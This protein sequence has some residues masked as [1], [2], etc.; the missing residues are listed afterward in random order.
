MSNHPE[1]GTVEVPTLISTLGAYAWRFVAFALALWVLGYV[2][3]QLRLVVIPIAFALFFAALLRPPT[4]F[5]ID[6]GAPRVVAA[7]LVLLTSLGAFS[8]LLVLSGTA[9]SGQIAEV[10][11]ALIEGWRRFLTWVAETFPITRA[12][13][14]EAI[15]GLQE[16]FQNGADIG[17]WITGG[18]TFGFEL[19]IMVALAIVTLFFFLK[20]GPQ[21]TEWVLERV[22]GDRRPRAT[23]VS[24]AVWTTFGGFARGQA[25]IAVVDAVA[26]YIAFTLLGVPL[27]LPLALLTL[28]GGFIPLVGPIVAGAA[29]GLVALSTGGPLLA[30]WAVLAMLAIQQIEGN[31]LEPFVMGRFLPLHPL[32]VLLAVATG[33]ALA[34]IIG[35]F[36]AVPIAAS[37]VA[38]VSAFIRRAPDERQE[39]EVDEA[40]PLLPEEA[41]ERSEV[42]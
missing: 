7:L 1:R 11:E 10:G 13:L 27:A 17:G 42:S 24:D 23:A 26:A 37:L 4:A 40:E 5:L 41:R 19:L 15:G 22:P 3:G 38:G 2:V 35:A 16:T 21:M 12:Q 28:I 36:V 33:G 25:L 9:I 30:L 6:R 8:G 29:A 14:D 39:P 34:G 20:D 32:M 18:L 31:V